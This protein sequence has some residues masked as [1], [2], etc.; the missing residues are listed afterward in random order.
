[1]ELNLLSEEVSISYDDVNFVH[2]VVP[3]APRVVGT[4]NVEFY[5]YNKNR[6][7]IF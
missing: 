6:N 7:M 3:K 5:E 4:L 1:M 2:N